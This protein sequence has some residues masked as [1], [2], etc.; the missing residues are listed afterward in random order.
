ML[1]RT[2]IKLCVYQYCPLLHVMRKIN[3]A[4]LSARLLDRNRSTQECLR[5]C[6]ECAR[7]SG[8]HGVSSGFISSSEPLCFIQQHEIQLGSLCRV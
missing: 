7:A 4:N 6:R 3:H 8:H 2:S 5:F 1:E